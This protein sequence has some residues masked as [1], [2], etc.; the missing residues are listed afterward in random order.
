MRQDRQD[1]AHFRTLSNVIV[2]RLSRLAL[3]HD[4]VARRSSLN[5]SPGAQF[6][7]Q[8]C[9]DGPGFELQASEIYCPRLPLHDTLTQIPISS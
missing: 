8:M 5:V 9:G 6:K 7:E 2:R 1:N 3:H 4:P